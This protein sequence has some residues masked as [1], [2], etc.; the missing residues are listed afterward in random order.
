VDN[1]AIVARTF[2]CAG[3]ESSIY[4]QQANTLGSSNRKNLD[5]DWLKE[6]SQRVQNFV[7]YAVFVDNTSA[8]LP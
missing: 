2:G 7:G 1:V 5:V 8:R 4:V 6:K 3:M